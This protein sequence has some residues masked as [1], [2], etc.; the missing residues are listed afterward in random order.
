MNFGPSEM[1]ETG[2]QEDE[3]VRLGNCALCF[4]YD[5]EF[6]SGMSCKL[7]NQLIVLF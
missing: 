7:I 2:N 5:K 1:V 3:L 6:L 4:T